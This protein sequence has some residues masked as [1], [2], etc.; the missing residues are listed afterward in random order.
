MGLGPCATHAVCITPSW[1]GNASRSKGRYAQSRF[2]I[3]DNE[4]LY[5]GTISQIWR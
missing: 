5:L 3:L 1:N 2:M 4:R